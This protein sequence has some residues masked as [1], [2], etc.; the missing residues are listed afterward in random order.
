VRAPSSSSST[1]D[2]FY[3]MEVN[4]RLQVEH[5]VT[6]A[7]TGHRPGRVA[8]AH[9]ARRGAAPG[10]ADVAMRG[11]AIEVRLTAEDEQFSP[12]AGVVQRF[13]AP[14]GV[15]VEHALDD[16]AVV[17]PW[18]DSMLGKLIAHATTRDAAIDALAAALEATT[19]L[20]IPT[21]RRLLI[22]SL[23]DPVFRRG[24]ALIPFLAGARRR[25]AR[26]AGRARA[27]AA[28]PACRRLLVRAGRCGDHARGA[29]RAPD[30]PAPPRR[31]HRRAGPR[32][33]P[34]RAARR[35]RRTSHDGALHA[36]G[37]RRLDAARRRR[38]HPAALARLAPTEWHVQLG[39][40]DAFIAEASFEP[41][42]PMRAMPH[43]R[44]ARR[45]AAASWPSTR[46]PAGRWRRATRSLSSSR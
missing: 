27:R 4:T 10:A 2:Q 8:A 38:R 5:P 22:E 32:A 21:N 19:V 42:A 26:G 40:V 18:Y 16:G 29:V 30:A 37:R 14:R 31:G 20:G 46:R 35:H 15:R 13:V 43:P 9:R 24:A 3:L 45:S 17:P 11:H 36:A 33:G 28:T 23:R 41:V 6:E 34:R 7:R 12:H 39:D 44:S 1:A 25:P